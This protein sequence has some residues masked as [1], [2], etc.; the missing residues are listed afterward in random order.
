MRIESPFKPYDVIIEADSLKKTVI[1]HRPLTLIT[2]SGV[3]R[4]YIETMEQYHG[5]D[6]KLSVDEGEASKS[7]DTYA[8]LIESMQKD[9]FPR[10]G[11]VIA[12]GGGMINDLAGFAAA[13]YKRGVHLYLV[14]TTLTAMVD[15]AIGGKF[16]V[17]TALAKNSIGTFYTPEKV[18]ADPFTLETL[19]RK[20]LA[21][22][23]AE[24]IKIALARDASFFSQLEKK[25]PAFNNPE[26]LERAVYLKKELVEKD[27]FDKKERRLLNLGHT[28][29][30][31]LETMH[32]YTY[33]HGEC[34]A[35][36]LRIISNGTVY[37]ERLYH[38]LSA[39]GLKQRIPWTADKLM[40]HIAHDKK[41]DRDHID[42]PLVKKVGKGFI[43]RFK[44]EDVKAFLRGDT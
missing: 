30:H 15:A 43:E 13:T 26:M 39:Y 19:P 23:M 42:I 7:L 37:E 28:F 25:H 14:P 33:T 44:T 34:V 32:G 18:I 10:E 31:A 38:L 29:A 3:P 41:T 40:Q 11:S 12:L 20:N 4:S 35:E 21:E 24:V 27:P 5:I 22:G 36:G 16:A 1:E 17:N 9:H 6:L 8:R 2:D